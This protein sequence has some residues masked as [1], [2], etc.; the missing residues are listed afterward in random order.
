MK[1]YLIFALTFGFCL[2]Q[3]PAPYSTISAQ[4]T[5]QDILNKNKTQV[6]GQRDQFDADKSNIM[7]SDKEIKTLMDQTLSDIKK[8]NLN[9]K[10]ELTE[11]MKYEISDITGAKA[12]VRDEKEVQKER[13]AAVEQWNA[14]LKKLGLADNKRKL[15]EQ[16]RLEEEQKRLNEEKRLA[17]EKKKA[18]EKA[19]ELKRIAEEQ[20]KLDEAKRLS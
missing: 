12:P 15:E 3:F 2:L 16:K 5:I 11:Q 14:L 8:R 4:M 6:Q 17:E 19:K 7:R 10:V 18:D 20:K 9:F 1:K 13:D